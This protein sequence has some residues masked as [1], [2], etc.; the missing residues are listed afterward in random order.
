[1]NAINEMSSEEFAAVCQRV[2]DL[3]RRRMDQAVKK[4]SRT[5]GLVERNVQSLHEAAKDYYCFG[6]LM[7]LCGNLGREVTTLRDMLQFVNNSH[8][9]REMFPSKFQFPVDVES[10]DEFTN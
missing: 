6:R 5:G 1:M 7:A 10:D 8:V 3:L 4:N 9:Q 2:E